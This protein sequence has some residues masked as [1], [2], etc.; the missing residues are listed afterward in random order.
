MEMLYNIM[1][2]GYKKKPLNKGKWKRVMG[3]K[4]ERL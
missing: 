2:M 4:V 1:A 3:S